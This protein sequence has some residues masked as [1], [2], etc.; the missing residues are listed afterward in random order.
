VS[1][2]KPHILI[3][4]AL[5]AV[6]ILCSGANAAPTITSWSNDI[7]GDN[8]EYPVVNHLQF[9]NMNVVA[10]EAIVTWTWYVDDV[11]TLH[12]YDNAS[13]S[14][15][16]PFN[17]NVSVIG[18]NAGGST[19]MITWYPVV[20]RE[21]ATEPVEM[22][23]E[24]AYDNILTSFSDDTDFEEF[25]SASTLPYTLVI[26]RLFFLIVYGVFFA[27]LWIRQESSIIPIVLG[28]SV[29]GLLLGFV[30]EDFAQTAVL[31]IIIGAMGVLYSV[32]RE[33]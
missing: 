14:F 9:I 31:F 20:C 4:S 21:L 23:N 15:S 24:T 3:V 27:M 2:I 6:L 11:D 5:I 22:L 1:A 12:N 8:S 29:G 13:V 10:D 26:G 33:R 28:F 32:Y 30:S 18:T 16:S 17:H 25:L 7:T 19:Q